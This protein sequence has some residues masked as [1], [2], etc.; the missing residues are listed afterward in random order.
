MNL[1]GAENFVSDTNWAKN[2]PL[3]T[4]KVLEF[5]PVFN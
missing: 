5:K 3:I 2:L 4:G 1:F